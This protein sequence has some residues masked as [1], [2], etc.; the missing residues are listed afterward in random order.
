MAACAER[1]ASSKFWLAGADNLMAA[2][3]NI[4]IKLPKTVAAGEI[5]TIKTLISHQMESGQ[6]L[7]ALGVRIPRS[8]IHR[9]EC[10]FEG[11]PVLDIEIQPGVALNPFFE[12]DAKVDV[13]GV[14]QFAWHD[15]DGAVYTDT[16][17]IVVS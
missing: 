13:S 12:F 9:F 14:F 3:V 17:S 15:D 16:A 5:F 11:T 10:N 1:R 7:N 2:G 6:R 8:I 4:R